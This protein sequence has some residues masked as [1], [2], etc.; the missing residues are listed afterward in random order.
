M[1]EH[2]IM[3]KILSGAGVLALSTVLA[4]PATAEERSTSSTPTIRPH[5]TRSGKR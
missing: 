5:R 2:S 1:R 4:G 3:S